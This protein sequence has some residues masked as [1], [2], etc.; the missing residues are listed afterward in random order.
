MEQWNAYTKDG[1]RTNIILARGMPIPRGLYHIVCETLVRHTDGDFLCML[2]AKEKATFAGYYEAT[3][4]GSALL[5]ETPEQCI[6]RELREETG[7]TCTEFIP[8]AFHRYEDGQS[9]FYSYVCQVNCDKD[10]VVLQ[11]GETEKYQW[12]NE[13]E[14]KE[15]LSSGQLVPTQKRRYTEYYRK[16]GFL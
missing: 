14:F 16:L 9:L 4:G 12:M 10:S 5:D 15:L 3:A 11:E 1:E 6:S 13:D 7:L 8:I 2:R